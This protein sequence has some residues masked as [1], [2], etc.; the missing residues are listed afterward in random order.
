MTVPQLVNTPVLDYTL[1][2][3]YDNYTIKSN[4]P[5]GSI[6]LHLL[7]YNG[8]LVKVMASAGKTGTEFNTFVNGICNLII[9]NL[10]NDMLEMNIPL[11]KIMSS[12]SGMGTDKAVRDGQIDVRSGVD[13]IYN[14]L[15]KY[16]RAKFD[17]NRVRDNGSNHRRLDERNDS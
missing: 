9:C 4:S 16:T 17:E 13:G 6:Y 15:S 8:R 10:I 2:K 14:A 12:I 1:I 5:A 3:R 11:I 7:E